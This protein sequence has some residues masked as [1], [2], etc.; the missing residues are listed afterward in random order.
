M[1]MMRPIEEFSQKEID[2]INLDDYEPFCIDLS[3]YPGF[4]EAIEE[5]IKGEYDPDTDDSEPYSLELLRKWWV[6]THEVPRRNI[7][8]N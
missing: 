2:A 1:V 5:W 6:L 8:T 7:I 3:E 4:L